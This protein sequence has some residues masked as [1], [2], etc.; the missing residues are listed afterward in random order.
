MNSTGLP[1][2]EIVVRHHCEAGSLHDSMK[3]WQTKQKLPQVLL[4]TGMRGVGKRSICHYLA[5]WILCEN[6]WARSSA[7]QDTPEEES[8]FG[9]LLPAEA[10]LLKSLPAEPSLS[11]CGRCTACL[12]AIKGSW[13]DFMEIQP[14]ENGEDSAENPDSH[15]SGVLKIDQFRKV[16][17]SVGFSGG[18]QG[19][20]RIILIPN[21]ERMTTQAANSV[22]KLL[23][24]PPVG[25]IFLLTSADPS[26]LLPTIVSR[27]QQLRLKPFSKNEINEILKTEISV[28]GS[29]DEAKRAICCEMA[30]GS[31]GKAML[32]T[33]SETWE[34]RKALIEFISNPKLQLG[35][36]VE[37]A[38]SAP[39]NMEKLID[40]LEIFLADL[41]RWSVSQSTPENY[42]KK[43]LWIN[44]DA[45]APLNSLAQKAL[46]TRGAGLEV[47]REIWIQHSRRLAQARIDMTLPLNRKL[48][49]QDL[50]MPW[51]N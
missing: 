8:L 23:E 19:R 18:D 49:A 36:L 14:E 41:I 25:W 26:L 16:K 20:Y 9:G 51:L 37:W 33:E 22:L 47:T 43:G 15:N 32:W 4:I 6:T 7:T 44:Q 28:G 1:L 40:Q 38:A 29:L 27:C 17:S 10:P 35:P 21:A 30:Q 12:N 11:P 31:W 2:P 42:A 3:E 45:H 13:V 46:D 50:L 24:E 48:L 34:K 39:K 5:Q